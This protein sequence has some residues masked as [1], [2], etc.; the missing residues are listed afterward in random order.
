MDQRNLPGMSLSL[1]FDGPSRFFSFYTYPGLSH[2]SLQLQRS[3]SGLELSGWPSPFCTTIHQASPQPVPVA[4]HIGS[5]HCWFLPLESFAPCMTH[6]ASQVRNR[7]SSCLPC[8]PNLPALPSSS[9][10]LTISHYSPDPAT[11][12][13]QHHLPP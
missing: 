11:G 3:I 10:N 5:V 8:L 2:P 1:K 13:T 4:P 12:S 9:S 7:D 6:T